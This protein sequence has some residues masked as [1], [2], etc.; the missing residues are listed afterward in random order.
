MRF[1]LIAELAAGDFGWI[2]TR[3][4]LN[5]DVRLRQEF[6][7]ALWQIH[8]SLAVL[9]NMAVLALLI[10]TLARHEAE[11]SWFAMA[12]VS[13]L[14]GSLFLDV[15]L[16]PVLKVGVVVPIIALNGI[17]ISWCCAVPVARACIVAFFYQTYQLL[18]LVVLREVVLS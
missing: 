9:M 18:Y 13:T 12:Y 11:F 3:A 5:V 6:G 2:L 10:Y 15:V 8:A 4:P 16:A 17:L 1:V 7:L 14:V